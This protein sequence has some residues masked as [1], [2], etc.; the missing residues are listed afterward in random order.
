MEAQ[1]LQQ[2]IQLLGRAHE[3][4]IQKLRST[5][6]ALEKRVRDLQTELDTTRD[7][8]ALGRRR[9]TL[10]NFK[11]IRQKRWLA[12]TGQEADAPVTP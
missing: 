2:R 9:T 1:Q 11:K 8:H 6:E 12:W 5:N 4:E 7:Q 10:E 3:A